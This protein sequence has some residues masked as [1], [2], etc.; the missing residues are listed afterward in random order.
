M[1][2]SF[3][4]GGRPLIFR[5]LKVKIGDALHGRI[6]WTSRTRVVFSKYHLHGDISSADYTSA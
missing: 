6:S 5:P 3:G 2:Q 1:G 4:Y